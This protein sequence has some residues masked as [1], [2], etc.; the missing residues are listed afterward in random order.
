MKAQNPYGRL[1]DC[2]ATPVV[3]ECA[4][5]ERGLIP[6]PTG[7]ARYNANG[8]AVY[9]HTLDPFQENSE[10]V[11]RSVGQLPWPVCGPYLGE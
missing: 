10:H 6:K 3:L 9:E 7:S 5:G 2:I 1:K 11:Y 4:S 8:V